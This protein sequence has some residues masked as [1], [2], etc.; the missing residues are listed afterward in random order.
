MVLLVFSVFAVILL[1]QVGFK[2]RLLT[3]LSGLTE[4]VAASNRRIV[5]QASRYNS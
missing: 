4:Y 5:R 3:R 1:L 2:S